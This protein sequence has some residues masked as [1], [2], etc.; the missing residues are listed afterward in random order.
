MDIED[1]VGEGADHLASQNDHKAGQYHQVDIQSLQLVYQG[2][3]HGLA[4][5]VVLSG[6]HIAGDAGGLGPLQGIGAGGGGND[7]GDSTVD[8]LTP[9]LGVD[10][11]VEIGAAPGYQN[12]DIFLLTN[13]TPSLPE[14]TEPT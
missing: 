4:G 12:R 7:S 10:E 8:Q 2:R 11:G 13:S 3:S 9:P 14:T 5:G 1:G 6:R